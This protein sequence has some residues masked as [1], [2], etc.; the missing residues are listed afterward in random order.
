M[1]NADIGKIRSYGNSNIIQIKIEKMGWGGCL[2]EMHR[3]IEGRKKSQAN[4][5]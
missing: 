3:Y 5:Q 2:K 4:Y 1:K